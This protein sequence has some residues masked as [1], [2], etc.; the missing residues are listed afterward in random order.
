MFPGYFTPSPLAGSGAFLKLDGTNSP[1]ATIDWGGNVL[2]NLLNNSQL[3]IQFTNN[4]KN[5]ANS[6]GSGL[7]M[8][9]AFKR[10]TVDAKTV[11]ITQL[12]SSDY[13]DKFIPI[14]VIFYSGNVIAAGLTSS[15]IF[16][17]GNNVTN[18]NLVVAT[19][20]TISIQKII[21]IPVKTTNWID[22][23]IAN[24]INVEVTLAATGFTVCDIEV[25]IA[26]YFL[27]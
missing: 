19:S 14:N 20:M 23:I 15:A 1:S 2:D 4:A 10:V 17:V 12:H 5:F 18:N 22:D 16:R 26:G 13:L 27:P 21:Q 24:P 25:F 11:G 9:L 6:I 3:A 7:G 8:T